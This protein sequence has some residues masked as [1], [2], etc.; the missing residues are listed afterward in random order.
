MDGGSRWKA[1]QRG[2][3]GRNTRQHTLLQPLAKR[4]RS[5]PMEHVCVTLPRFPSVFWSVNTL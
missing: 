1:S 2:V 5:D 4:F 3:N